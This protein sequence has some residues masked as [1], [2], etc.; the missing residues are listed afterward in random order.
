MQTVTKRPAECKIFFIHKNSF[1]RIAVTY[2][3]LAVKYEHQ[4]VLSTSK[5]MKSTG[6]YVEPQGLGEG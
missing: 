1:H 4:E 6:C 5:N 2:E 3:D